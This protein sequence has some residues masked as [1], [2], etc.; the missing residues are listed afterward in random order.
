[1]DTSGTV[2]M[3]ER[4]DDILGGWY[5]IGDEHRDTSSAQH[6]LDQLRAQHDDAGR[7]RFVTTTIQEV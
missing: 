3:I 2:T 7:F 5:E 4:W 6:Q 1:M